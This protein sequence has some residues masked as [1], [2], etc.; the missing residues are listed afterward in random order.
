M[1]MQ[2]IVLSSQLGAAEY[3]TTIDDDMGAVQMTGCP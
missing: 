3:A 2:V 1:V